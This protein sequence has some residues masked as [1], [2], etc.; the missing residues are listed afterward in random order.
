MPRV[1]RWRL[2]LPAFLVWWAVLVP[3][4]AHPARPLAGS[5]APEQVVRGPGGIGAVLPAPGRGVSAVFDLVDGTSL[6]LRLTRTQ[7]GRL[8]RGTSPEHSLGA[9]ASAR[10]RGPCRDRAHT[11]LGGKWRTPL[12]WSFKASTTP[13]EVAVSAAELAVRRGA[14]NMAAA[15]NDCRRPDRVGAAHDYEGRTGAPVGILGVLCLPADGRSVVGWGLMPGNVLA[16][17]CNHLDGETIVESDVLFN[18][19]QDWYARKPPGCDDR[20][21]I[22]AVMTHE[23]GHSFG[24]G[25]VG[26]ARHGRLTMST[27]VGP[28]NDSP[29]TLGL[30]DMLGLEAL[31]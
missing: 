30:G 5:G 1:P 15:V 6:E 14:R 4:A 10:P 19:L 26:E 22:Q 9:A 18:R 31:Y 3:T 25:H 8:L 13:R 2:L 24:L 17:T 16:G 12:A 21:S 20:F 27:A 23:R 29:S 28:C 7:E 11:L